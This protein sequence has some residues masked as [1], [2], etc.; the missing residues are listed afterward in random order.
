[1]FEDGT[2]KKD[3]LITFFCVLCR[4]GM[5]LFLRYN[6]VINTETTTE[7]VIAMCSFIM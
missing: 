6:I 4:L 3:I 1:M 5:T 7:K 2:S